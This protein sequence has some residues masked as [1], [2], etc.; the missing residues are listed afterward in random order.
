[1]HDLVRA[2]AACR[3]QV[4]STLGMSTYYNEKD[5]EY[6]DA[7]V[8]A[9]SRQEYMGFFAKAAGSIPKKLKGVRLP[10]QRLQ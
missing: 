5:A 6:G 7:S 8:G 4:L 9:K 10:L 2:P 1:M 3:R